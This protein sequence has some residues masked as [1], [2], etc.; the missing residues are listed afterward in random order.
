MMDSETRANYR[1]Q[2]AYL[3]A[4]CDAAEAVEAA[5]AIKV[6]E[7]VKAEDLETQKISASNVALASASGSVKSQLIGNI[8]EEPT[9]T[10]EDLTRIGFDEKQAVAMIDEGAAIRVAALD[11]RKPVEGVKP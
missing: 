1:K 10:A 11:L 9:A 5:A 3:S 2:A 7:P 8:T 4:L 6:E